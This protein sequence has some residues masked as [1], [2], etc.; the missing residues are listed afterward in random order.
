MDNKKNEIPDELHVWRKTIINRF[1]IV[2]AIAATAGTAMTAVD[3]ISRPDQWQNVFIYFSLVVLLLVLAIFRKVDDR[4]RAGGV[5][6]VAYLTG[7]NA[8]ASLGLSGS[9]RLYML[10]LPVIALILL[11]VRS[12]IVMSIISLITLGAFGFLFGKTTLLQGM[13]IERNTLQISDWIAESSD[14]LMLLL[15]VM[16][17]LILFYRFQ[18]GL[19]NKERSARADLIHAQTLLEEQNQTLEEKV[20]DRTEE[21]S[22]SNR[23]QTALYKIADATSAS[24]DINEFFAQIHGIVSELMYAGN[25]FVALYDEQSGLL[26]FPYFVD[27][28]DQ[29]LPP[30]PLEKFHGM[31]SYV[32]RTGNSFK[33]GQENF[34]KL[35]ESGDIELTGSTNVDGIGAPLKFEGKTIGAIF[36]QSYTEGITYTDQDDEL[37][38]FVANHIATATT[39]LQALSAEHLRNVELALLNDLSRE[40]SKTLDVNTVTRIVGDKI[41]TIFGARSVLIMLL[42]RQTDLIQVPYEYDEDEGGYIDYV[43][44]FPLGKGLSS[45]VITTGKPLM[46]GTLEEEIANGAYFPPEIIEKGAGTLSQSWLGVPIVTNES[47][48]GL[49]AL[50]DMQ[51]YAYNEA[52]KELLQTLSSSLG[53]SIE[54]ARLFQAEQRRNTELAVINSVQQSLASKLDKETIYEL[55]GE[56]TRDVFHVQ[57]VDIVIHDPATNFNIHALFL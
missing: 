51:P 44:P 46:V 27:E 26:S 21:L 56:K 7:L 53:A 13:F 6:L 19:I 57:I 49:V 48:I 42:D 35:V 22:R 47:V 17:I 3:A 2:S 52:N 32:I 28:K 16:V 24:N 50:A 38:T 54:N 39:R 36:V 40:M 23:I 25:F 41:R 4:I 45:K 14:T 9:G 43:E 15:V 20:N 55:I 10:A 31:T 37:L 30:Q 5:L 12:G 8:F 33:H 18:E 11:G 1:L 29:P 34:N